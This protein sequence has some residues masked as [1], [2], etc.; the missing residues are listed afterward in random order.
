MVAGSPASYYE[1]MNLESALA[2]VLAQPH[3]LGPRQAFATL[4]GG[5]RGAFIEAQLRSSAALRADPPS[6]DDDAV[7][8]ADELLDNHAQQWA[9]GAD[10]L[11]TGVTFMRGFI[12]L[13]AVDASWFTNHWRA[14]FARAPIRQ[15]IVHGL[16]NPRQFFGC[17]GLQQLVGLTFNL[18]GTAFSAETFDDHAAAA[19]TASPNLAQL[20]Y[21]DV[22]G[23]ALTD[24][25]KLSILRGLPALQTALFDDL[26]E[27]VSQDYDGTLTGVL[28]S[29]GL[30][31]FEKAHGMFASLHE[32]SR[33]N[34]SVL[35][36]RY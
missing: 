25:G 17:A 12:E 9:N 18:Y 6:F 11:T 21:L 27:T 14:L 15:L 23:T 28:E 26:G 1:R 34:A 22:T 5:T 10:Q 8:L 16:N 29:D 35:R 24:V 33:I 36:E 13:V 19:L 3:E 31:A 30:V 7:I 2:T 20:R 32:V 4:V